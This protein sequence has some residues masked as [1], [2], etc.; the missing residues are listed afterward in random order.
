MI[1]SIAILVIAASLSVGVSSAASA[2]ESDTRRCATQHE[3]WTTPGD[4][5]RSQVE[6]RWD[7]AGKGQRVYVPAIGS[8]W[9]YPMCDRKASAVAAFDNGK[10][11]GVGVYFPNTNEPTEPAPVPDP[12]VPTFD[13]GEEIPTVVLNP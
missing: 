3:I 12:T 11:W 5:T 8:A 9:L 1:K 2:V 13:P 7:V 6:R 10:V 4:L